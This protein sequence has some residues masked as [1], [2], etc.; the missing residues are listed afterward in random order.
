MTRHAV[1]RPLRVLA[2]ALILF[3]A[4]ASPAVAQLMQ[5][6]RP[7]APGGGAAGAQQ[8][9]S[10][11]H[12]LPDRFGVTWDVQQDGSIGDGGNDL[13]DGASKLMVAGQQFNP[14]AQ[15]ALNVAANELTFNA[16]AFGA[17]RVSRRVAVNAA[18][19]WCRYVEVLENP[20]AQPLRASLRLN[21]DMGQGIQQAQPVE[22]LKKRT[23]LGVVVF[24]GRRAVAMLG[25]GVGGKVQGR[26]VAQQN[27]DQCDLTVDVDVP[28]KQTAA[29]VHFQAMRPGIPDAAGF[30]TAAKE[31]ELL[32]DLPE[33][34]RRAIVNFRRAGEALVGDVELPRADLLDT[35]ELRTGDV[36]RGTLADPTFKIET[37]H[38]PVEL[39]AD[40][41]IGMVSVGTHRPAQLFVTARRE[42][43][44]GALAGG[45]LR[46]QLSSGQ[47]LSVPV[48]AVAK[49]GCRK[50][51]GEPEEVKLDQPMA[52]L[53]DGQR[54][55]VDMPAGPIAV[56]TLYGRLE[57][58]PE[59]LAAI[60]FHGEEQAVHQVRLRDGSR[61]SCVVAGDDLELRLRGAA[62]GAASA[63]APPPT[64][65]VPLASLS[66][67]QFVPPTDD[68]TDGDAPTLTLGNGDVLAGSA[69]GALELETGFDV[70]R[71]NGPEVRAI[72]HVEPPEGGRGLPSE[73]TVTLWDGA[74][75]SGR[76]KGDAV[77]FALGS[78]S[79]VRVPVALI[80][81][82]AHPQPSAPQ[83]MV[84]R[85]GEIVAQLNDP[86]WKKRDRA[87][88]QIR[89]IGQ[90][91]V[92][93]LKELRDKQ[94]PEA[95]Q[96][97]DLILKS[98]EREKAGK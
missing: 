3:A 47:L 29:F 4:A 14:Q 71:M 92:G 91:A 87:A 84:K 65:K 25:G 42:I 52:L 9:V 60:H 2:G 98:L 5:P 72:R 53:R 63:S 16:Q 48:A 66:R 49:V 18:A 27:S 31:K 64:V 15:A 55:I 7:G 58:R 8:M 28:A 68:A 78:G 30:M 46:V 43:I 61:F 83:D 35:V 1:R 32:G 22:D 44:G 21:F 34:V 23:P 11:P 67:L 85:V 96:Q 20:T 54:L 26:Y 73:L 94:P 70:I 95:Q 6:V 89:S 57:L 79:T 13:Y 76:L 51:P 38:G 80:D 39:P 77:D 45:V 33:E 40:Q 93:V 19:G 12:V 74:S 88:A 36:Y 37:F 62:G 86:D 10:L 82:Y 69:A 59:S 50:R 17:L 41:V 56:S 24:D 97:I 81:R 90:P 75:L